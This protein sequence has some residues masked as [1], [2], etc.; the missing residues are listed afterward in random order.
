MGRRSDDK[1]KLRLEEP[2]FQRYFQCVLASMSA[3]RWG[4]DVP[5]VAWILFCCQFQLAWLGIETS[6]WEKKNLSLWI[7]Q[8]SLRICRTTVPFRTSLQCSVSL[9]GPVDMKG[10]KRSSGEPSSFAQC[11]H[12]SVAWFP[13]YE[14]WL[15][16]HPPVDK[17]LGQKFQTPESGF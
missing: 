6:K 3:F 12:V 11:G 5:L 9:R 7:L 13:T 10:P 14:L 17:P 15:Q 1:Y 2:S 16:V 4:V 8:D